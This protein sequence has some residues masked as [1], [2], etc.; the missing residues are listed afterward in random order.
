[1]ARQ[2]LRSG[3]GLPRGAFALAGI[4][5]CG[6]R[7]HRIGMSAR[8]RALDRAERGFRRSQK[9]ARREAR[10]GLSSCHIR[11]RYWSEV[12][13]EGTLL[14]VRSIGVRQCVPPK[15]KR[16]EVVSFSRK[17]RRRMLRLFATVSRTALGRSL[18]V[19]LTYPRS[20]PTESSTYKRHFLTFSKRLRR[21]FPT[22]SAIWKLEFQERGA[23]HF[24]L[25]VMGVP[26][27]A[28]QWLSRAWFQIVGSGDDRHF[29]AGTQ[30]QRAHSTRKTL[31]YVAKYVAKV[32]STKAGAHTGRFWGVVGRR[33]LDAHSLDWQLE[34]GGQRSLS[35]AVRT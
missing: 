23:P 28:R 14:G 11:P 22:S 8:S 26:F 24:H 29:R 4:F 1:M 25:I 3:E 6:V 13:P 7:G 27:L 9:I 31:A 32:S 21:T 18:L 17:S 34:R 19:T 30:V 15:S 33:S 2:V 16:G 10:V 20:F 35:R 5:M 12:A